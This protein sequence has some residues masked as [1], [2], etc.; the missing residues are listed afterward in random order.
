MAVDKTHPGKE[1]QQN[2]DPRL[3]KDLGQS[4]GGYD[5]VLT[6]VVFALFG[7]WLDKRFGFTPVLTIVMT[8]VG[9]T[10]AV[11]NVYYRY[12]REIE[13]LEAETAALRTAGGR[14]SAQ[15]SKAA[16]GDEGR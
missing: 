8:V 10:G 15:A 4:T 13:R 11:L 5:L 9:F 3:G 14:G 2:E 6:G 7:L 1:P 16:S 12:T